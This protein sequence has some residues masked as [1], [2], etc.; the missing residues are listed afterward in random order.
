MADRLA[1][2]QLTNDEIQH[3]HS[4]VGVCTLFIH[5]FCQPASSYCSGMCVVP[6]VDK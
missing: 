5:I 2:L 6:T 4:T 3:K 1:T